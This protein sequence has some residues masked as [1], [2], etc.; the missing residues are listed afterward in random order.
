MV[1][2]NKNDSIENIKDSN[3]MDFLNI[4]IIFAKNKK[5]I[6]LFPI[7]IGVLV[8]GISLLIPN[9]YTAVAVV[10]PP[11]QQQNST[12]ALLGQ[13]GALGGGAAAL[14]MKNPNDTYISMLESRTVRDNIIK[15]FDLNTVY[16]VKSSE[17]SRGELE[18]ASIF[19][20]G[21]DGM[22]VLK[23]SDAD[24]KRAAEMTNAFVDELQKLTQVLAFTEASQ[25][26]V[27]FEKQLSTAKDNL[28]VAEVNLKQTQE[29]TGLIQLDSQA[30]AIIRS[31]AD[32]KT[33]IAEKEVA[34]SS[35]RTFATANNP[36]YIQ[37]QKALEGLQNQLNK[38]ETG[39][40]FGPGNTS[41][42][43]SKVPEVALEYVRRMRDLKAS[44]GIYEM[45]LKQL[46]LAKVDE[47]KQ[48]TLIQVL[49]NAIVPEKKSGPK[50]LIIVVLSVV[51]SFFLIVLFVFAKEA[52]SIFFSDKSQSARVR[53]LKD[54]LKWH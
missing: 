30:T 23:V 54:S 33:A 9:R 22:I 13:L 18:K 37:T 36:L 48:S 40:N 14:G 6:F 34:L 45:M 25:R 47:A 10:L 19:S 53:K 11:Q 29:K 43:T 51:I 52:V 31:S 15:R 1:V 41:I 7:L 44:E 21:K 32:L 35:M 28:S 20:S 17:D 42:S 24:P 12:S 46:E 5:L 8:A 49:D 39:N 38:L 4:V 27:F 2:E 26:R 3:N 16:K 50:R